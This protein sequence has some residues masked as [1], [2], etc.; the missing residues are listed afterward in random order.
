MVYINIVKHLS[1]CACH[2][3]WYTLVGTQCAYTDPS[4]YN[5]EF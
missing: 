1:A 2:A 5:L 3:L 4:K